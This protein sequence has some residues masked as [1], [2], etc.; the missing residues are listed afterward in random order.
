MNRN[1][2]DFAPIKSLALALSAAAWLIAL[3][4]CETAAQRLDS[5]AVQ[6]IKPG[7][8]TR[9]EVLKEFG[10]PR[11]TTGANGRTLLFYGREFWG[12]PSRYGPT[13]D[14]YI[15]GLSVLLDQND[16]VLRTHYSSHKVDLTY[17]AGTVSAGSFV[18]D[19]LAGRI[20]TGVTTRKEAVA[21]LGE[22]AVE[23][24]TL[25]G[26][27]SLSWAYAESSF[28]GRGRWR[29]FHLLLNE[30]DVVI[31]VKRDNYR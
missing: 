30:A 20:R 9:Q 25:D 19:K 21:I 26:R 5:K 3:T 12:R 23:K 2:R 24:L 7:V 15:L 10:D 4:G 27:L 17:G 13:G 29:M 31:A 28:I 16:I 14:S 1:A 22:P 8:T 11:E 6:L 18:S